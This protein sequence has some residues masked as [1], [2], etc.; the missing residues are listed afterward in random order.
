M[1]KNLLISAYAI[2]PCKGSEFGAAWNTVTH[3][4]TRYNVFVLY[5]ISDDYLGDTQTMRAYINANPDMGVKFIEVQAGKLAKAITTLDKAGLGWFFYFAYNIWQKRALQAA[6]KL[7]QTV[8]IDVVH[9]LGPIGFREPGYL[10]KLNKPMV[11]GPI[12]GMMQV[13]ERLLIKQPPTV[14]FKFRI[15]NFINQLQLNFS[16]RI[17]LAFK[18]AG[19]LLATTTAGQ[20]TIKQKYSLDARYFPQMGID[21]IA[22]NEQKFTGLAHKVQLVWSG[23]H[24]HRKNLSMC[25]DA[26]ARI[27]ATNWQL[28]V[29]GS[30]PLTQQLKEQAIRLNID[31]QIIWHGQIVR[32]EAINIMS[33]AHLHI[34]TSIA[35][36]SPSVLT[37]AMSHGVP[38]LSID[39][40]GMSDVICDRCGI[41]IAIDTYAVMVDNISM[42][43]NALLTDPDKLQKLART[44]VDCAHEHT[45]DKRLA[46]L[47]DVYNEAILQHNLQTGHAIINEILIA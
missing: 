19:V 27:G 12:G 36:D 16:G 11:W 9:Q 22:L 13:D 43:I 30:G 3:L 2:S 6:R 4:A 15:K 47:D 20:Q 37:E 33:A 5:G 29:L 23:T 45:W 28:H 10:W 41:K 44:T 32:D 7:M 35:E 24:I 25:L 1:K 46:L 31:K 40:C 8:D 21:N 38:T 39:H 18:K 42:A 14:R 34:I 17:R 26:L